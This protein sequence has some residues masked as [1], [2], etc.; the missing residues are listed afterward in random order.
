MVY[1][2]DYP[3]VTINENEI[4][5]LGQNSLE[6]QDDTIVYV[7]HGYL[8]HLRVQYINNRNIKNNLD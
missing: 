3:S 2:E 6:I 1:Q 5:R 7:M 8:N 4:N